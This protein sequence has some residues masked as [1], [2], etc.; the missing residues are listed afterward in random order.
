MNKRGLESLLK[1]KCKLGLD[2]SVAIGPYGRDADAKIGPDTAFLVYAT[3]NGFLPDYHW[4]VGFQHR[5]TALMRNF[6]V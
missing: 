1:I 5:V 6:M 4:K 2:A 3:A